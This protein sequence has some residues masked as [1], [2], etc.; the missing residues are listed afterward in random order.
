MIGQKSVIRQFEFIEREKKL[1]EERLEYAKLIHK[2]KDIEL[3]RKYQE[4]KRK[5]NH[6]FEDG[7][8]SFIPDT[9]NGWCKL[10]GSLN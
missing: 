8:D 3:H 7:S 1:N 6:K 5:C 10:C 2:N 4:M 9:H